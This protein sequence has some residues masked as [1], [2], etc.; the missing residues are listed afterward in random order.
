M[1]LA[2]CM[3]ILNYYYS[4]ASRFFL[5]IIFLKNIFSED[6]AQFTMDHHLPAIWVDL[7]RRNVDG[8]MDLLCLIYVTLKE[9]SVGHRAQFKVFITF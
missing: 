4:C 1:K 6:W 8:K 9:V 2:I 5:H 3:Q 7:V